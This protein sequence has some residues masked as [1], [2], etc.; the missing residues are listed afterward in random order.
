MNK[1][2][3]SKHLW[4]LP[5]AALLIT[6]VILTSA[7]AHTFRQT[8]FSHVSAFSETLIHTHPETEEL[9]L[10]TLK[11]YR[12][13][14]EKELQKNT[15]LGTYGYR[16][17]EF[18]QKPEKHLWIC[19]LILFSACG[20]IFFTVLWSENRRN[21]ARIS[22]LTE[23]LEQIN[24]GHAGTAIQDTEDEFS[25]LQDEM[26][27]TVTELYQTREQAVKVRKDFADNLTNIAHQMKTPITS[28][29]LSCQ[30]L[31]QPG[32]GL[33]K[34]QIEKS[35]QRLTVLEE[36]L[37][38]LSRIDAGALQLKHTEIDVYTVLTLAAD[39]LCD[40]LKDA[41]VHV[42]IPEKA[43][44]SI[45]GDLEWTME[46]LI[47]LMKN[48]MEHSPC[49]ATIR[50]DYTKNPLYT[51]ILILD[52]GNGFDP[53]DIPHLFE[54]FYRGSHPSG[55]GVGIGLALAKSIVELQNGTIRARNLPNGGA[56]FEIRIYS[57]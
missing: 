10:T 7:W 53:D 9:V 29:L 17:D 45:C 35:L 49:G 32:S 23:Y 37:L 46:A 30:L 56:C 57:H 41:D 31:K 36:S 33:Y 11:T 27:K 21:K 19:T 6:A 38:T 22:E 52:E 39:N 20:G 18:C 40:L 25:M 51:E 26:Y 2:F 13:L 42:E 54:R 55:N 43:P 44:A 1:P 50:C 3:P 28:A 15:F 16:P 5:A 4:I 12:E 24:R 48:C 14:P 47:N 34:A 8:A